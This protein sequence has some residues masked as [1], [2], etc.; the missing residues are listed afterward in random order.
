MW[1]NSSLRTNQILLNKSFLEK[2]GSEMS[3]TLTM[4]FNGH[5]STGIIRLDFQKK[6]N[7][8][9]CLKEPGRIFVMAMIQDKFTSF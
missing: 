8:E 6:K 4:M 1:L 3:N 2:P 5:N 9:I 7:S